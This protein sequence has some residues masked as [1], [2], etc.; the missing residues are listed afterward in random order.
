MADLALPDHR[1]RFLAA[2]TWREAV[3]ETFAPLLADG[4]VEPRYVDAIVRAVG[5]GSGMYMDLGD[6]IM[7]AHT[8]PEQ[9]ALA[10][11]LCLGVLREPVLLGG[12]RGHPIRQVWGLCAT[13]AHSHQSTMAGLAAVLVNPPCRERIA[14]ARTIPDVLSAIEAA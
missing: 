9:G 1:I 12:H 2:P 6:G 5:D 7:L 14:A 4:Y 3:R 8:R 10:T 11:G 13:D